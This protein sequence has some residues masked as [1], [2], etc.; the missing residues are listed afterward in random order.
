MTDI[1]YIQ[2]RSKARGIGPKR[3]FVYLAASV[4]AGIA[5]IG[6]AAVAAVVLGDASAIHTMGP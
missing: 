2:D 3:G 1:A 4:I 6:T 5:L